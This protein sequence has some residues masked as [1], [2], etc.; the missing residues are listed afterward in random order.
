[1]SKFGSNNSSF[2]KR[3]TFQLDI[4]SKSKSKSSDKQQKKNKKIINQS[5]SISDNEF[6]KLME[7]NDTQKNDIKLSNYL[8]KIG[9]SEIVNK[10]IQEHIIGHDLLDK[11]QSESKNENIMGSQLLK[12]ILIKYNDPNDY[13]WVEQNQYGLALQF[14]LKDNLTDQ[15]LCLLLVQ[16]YSYSLEFPKIN[17]KDKQVYYLKIIFQLLFTFDII[18]ESI[19]WEWQETLT[20]FSDIDEKIKNT[21]CVQTAEFFNIL[22]MTFTDED[23]EDNKDNNDENTKDNNNNN[24]QL[25]LNTEKLDNESNTESNTESDNESDKYKVPEEQD[26]NMDDDNFN[27]DDL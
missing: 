18:D 11:I 12:Q 27:L 4:K 13:T 20:N 9:N 6:N 24:T 2:F 1:M 23:Y 19:Y 5:N 22:K 17:Y 3:N 16:N 10:L 21:I 25:K 7:E 26:Y 15:L 14:L 8:S